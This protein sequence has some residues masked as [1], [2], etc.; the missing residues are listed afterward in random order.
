MKIMITD[1]DHKDIVPETLV[2]EKSGMEFGMVQC[3][4]REDVIE[5][6]KGSIALIN[7]YAPL[8]RIVFKALPTVK[9]IIRYGVGVDN[10]NIKDATEYGIQVCNVP[11]YGVNEVADH[12]LALLMEKTRKVTKMNTQVSGGGWEYAEA[13][14]LRR[15]SMQTLGIVGLGRIGTAFANRVRSMGYNILG[16]DVDYGLKNRKFP[17][18]VEYVS[19]DE[20]LSRSDIISI[21]C[22]LNETTQDLFNAET[23]KKMK[24][25]SILLNVSRGGIIE[26]KALFEAVSSKQIGGAGIDV[27]KCEPLP[28]DHPFRTC[29]NI[30]VTPHMAWYSEDSAEELKR[31]CAE[32]CVLFMTGKPLRYQINTIKK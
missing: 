1:C 18:F 15:P 20:L 4:T 19:F 8:D 3:K 23:F 2:F 5:N 7:Q 11:D 32:E 10:I 31:K 24:K 13:I 25:D 21:H 6:C 16:F 17:D 12:A 29:E 22:S 30:T 27:A 14:P 26:E 28:A 9:F